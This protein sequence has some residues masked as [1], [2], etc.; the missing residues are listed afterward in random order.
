MEKPEPDAL[1]ARHDG[2][3]PKESPSE[4]NSPKMD[5]MVGDGIGPAL[6]NAGVP[7]SE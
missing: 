2:L 7:V 6:P 5:R 3:L 1:T 4:H